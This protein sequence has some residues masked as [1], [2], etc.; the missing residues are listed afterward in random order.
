[1]IQVNTIGPTLMQFG[2]DAQREALLPGILRGELFFGVGYTEPA[3]GT[4]LA[5][6]LGHQK[7]RADPAEN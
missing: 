4:D 2:S 3:A 1:M 7:T 5:A 6:L